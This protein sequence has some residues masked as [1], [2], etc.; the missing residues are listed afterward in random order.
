[1]FI[2]YK[3]RMFS[4]NLGKLNR[5]DWYLIL[6]FLYY[7][8]GI[9]YASGDI[10][11]MSL[12]GIIVVISL[13]YAVQVK[14]MKNKP[15]F[16]IVLSLLLFLFT[17][18][19][20]SL[21]I[22]HPG[23]VF[24]PKASYS[25]PSY[26]YIKQIYLSLLPIFSFYYYTIKGYLTEKRLCI[27]IYFFFISALLSFYRYQIDN[28]GDDSEEV[29]NN[30]G[31]LFLS[32]IPSLLLFRRNAMKMYLG[33]F[34][35]LVYLVLGMKRGAII[36]GAICMLYFL[37]SSIRRSHGVTKIKYIFFTIVL[38]V[39]GFYFVMYQMATSEYLNKRIEDTMEG[40]SSNRDDIYTSFW[41]LFFSQADV[42]NFVF[43]FGANGT[44]ENLGYF[45]HNDW[46]EIMINQGIIGFF[47]FLYFFVC[48]YKSWKNSI[49]IEA[50]TAL[51]ITGFIVLV[52][53]FFS[54]SYGDMTYMFTS[55]LG[56]YLAISNIIPSK[57]H[58]N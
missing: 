1:M 8:Q 17:V 52:R 9:L 20:F 30:M 22:M 39:V 35:I 12:L 4:L 29:T 7:L 57:L 15:V 25:L 40:D 28:A 45:A 38:A 48:Y 11:S 55:V 21:I 50:K 31:Y 23:V 24:Y 5:C 58:S 51:A 44:L 18:Y 37:F 26:M 19:G 47:I 42:T 54:M 32:L 43:G 16:F 10:L 13:Y 14:R 56:Y 41:N 2:F 36:V 34:V 49:N 53:S 33:L 3:E 46:L 6:W 27:W